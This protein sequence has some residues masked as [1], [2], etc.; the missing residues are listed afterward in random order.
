MT[1]VI[2]YEQLRLDNIKRNELELERL[3]LGS[4]T[5]KSK[6]VKQSK[7]QNAPNK[8]VKIESATDYGPRRSSSRN[9]SRAPGFFNEAS[10]FSMSRND[11]DNDEEYDN[12]GDEDVEGFDEESIPAPTKKRVNKELALLNNIEENEPVIKMEKAKT[13]RSSCRKCRENIDQDTMRVGMKA[14]IMGRSSW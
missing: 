10:Q 8:R 3:G 2:S 11:D 5:A 9:V 12:D 6:P 7:A 13:G 4:L 14:W 1:E